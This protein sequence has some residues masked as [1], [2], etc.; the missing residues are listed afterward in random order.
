VSAIQQYFTYLT[1]SMEQEWNRFWFTPASSQRLAWIRILAGLL[2]LYT[3][4]TYGLD[5]HRLFGPEGMLPSETIHILYGETWSY[6]EFIPTSQLNVI[7]WLGIVMVGLFTLGVGIRWTS[8]GA[9]IVLISY[10]QRAPVLTGQAEAVLSMLLV[11]L[12]VG[13]SGESLSVRTLLKKLAKT[14]AWTSGSP[15]AVSNTVAIRLI[16]IHLAVICLMMGFAQLSVNV[17]WTGEAIWLLADRPGGSLVDFTWLANH[18][19]WLG[20]WSHLVTAY[21]LAFPILIWNRLARPLLL[22]WSVAV[23]ISLALVSGQVMLCLTML[24]ALLAF[25]E[26]AGDLRPEVRE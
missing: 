24:V 23:W 15:H 16:Q 26:E 6:L 18:P 3:L 9:T 17:W 14:S 10:F 21:L 5:L 7:H 8:I 4:I 19:Q 12:C 2:G 25:V 13:R 20:A 22:V 11:Y 1:T